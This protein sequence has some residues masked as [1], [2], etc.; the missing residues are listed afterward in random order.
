ME[1]LGLLSPPL[2]WLATECLEVPVEANSRARGAI[3]LGRGEGRAC[4]GG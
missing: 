4:G 1:A 3:A 2:T